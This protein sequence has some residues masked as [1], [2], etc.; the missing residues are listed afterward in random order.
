MK[1][2]A[3]A[4]P[5]FAMTCFKLPV[6]TV[7][8]LT[9][10]MSDF[11]WN[12]S[13]DKKKIHWVSWDKLCLNK[14]LGGLGMKDTHCFN[15]ALLGKQA[16]RILN[17]SYCLLS[18]LLRSRYFGYCKFLQAVEGTRPSYG[19]KSILHG[20]ELLVTGLKKRIGNE[21]SVNVWTDKWIEDVHMRAPLIKK[22]LN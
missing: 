19:W 22:M 15:Q 17:F 1:F 18:R 11:L 5:I 20:R 6:T 9:S 13:E 3:M 16:W 8:T 21:K 4:M 10:A 2:V 14:N 12:S 7:T